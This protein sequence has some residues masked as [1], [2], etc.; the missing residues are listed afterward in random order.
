MARRRQSPR[1][2]TLISVSSNRVNGSRGLGC[3]PVGI[4]KGAVSP[5]FV[6][7]L[8]IE[9]SASWAFSHVRFN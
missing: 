2:D 3:R 9:V 8:C 5:G 4:L 7:L 6:A 1:G